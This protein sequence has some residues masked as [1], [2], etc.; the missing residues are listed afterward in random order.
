MS[1]LHIV[2]DSSAQL[3]PALC[4]ELEITV[5]P[6]PVVWDGE[7]YRDG[8]DIGPR[9]FFRRLRTSATFPTTSAPTPGDFKEMFEALAT[10]GKPILAILVSHEFSSTSVTANLAC[11]LL[12][13]VD[14]RIV[15]SSSVTMGLGFQVLAAA[16]AA[17]QGM[18]VDEVMDVVH[19]VA[20]ASGVV[21][22][23]AHTEY[24]RHGGRVSALGHFLASSLNITPVM[25]LNGGPIQPVE[26]LRS[27]NRVPARLVE[28][29]AERIQPARPLRLAV[30]HSDSEVRALKLMQ[31]VKETFAPDEIFVSEMPAVI[32]THIGPDALGLAYAYGI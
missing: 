13:D 2:T 19:R 5:V 17:A 31:K 7:T 30:L 3:P 28:L 12:T 9:A 22:T 14:I 4:N 15:D 11:D 20:Q 18:Q 1:E 21:F 16:R 6:L 29:V 23:V 10:D 25:E 24:L 27:P 32:G 26:R 8:I